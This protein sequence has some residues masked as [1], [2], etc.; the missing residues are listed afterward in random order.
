MDQSSA[1]MRGGSLTPR[2]LKE[3]EHHRQVCEVVHPEDKQ[4]QP[5]CV[6]RVAKILNWVSGAGPKAAET[7]LDG[8][9]ELPWLVRCRCG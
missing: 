5:G 2:P 9:F 8:R 6:A 1:G 4:H 3:G 7:T